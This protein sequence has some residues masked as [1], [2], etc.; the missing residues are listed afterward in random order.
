MVNIVGVDAYGYPLMHLG[1]R[2]AVGVSPYE[3]IKILC[4]KNNS[5]SS[6]FV[7]NLIKD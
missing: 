7:N 2:A 5:P 4:Y 1:F 6:P 3:K